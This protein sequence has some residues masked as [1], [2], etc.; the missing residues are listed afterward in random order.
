MEEKYFRDKGYVTCLKPNTKFF[1]LKQN[2]FLKHWF[3]CQFKMLKDSHLLV[4]SVKILVVNTQFSVALAT[5][6]SQF[7]TLLS[8][9]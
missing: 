2:Q 3:F 6:W 9:L 1:N 5:S 4:A 7:Q 8:H